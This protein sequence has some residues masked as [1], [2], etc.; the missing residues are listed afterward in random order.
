MVTSSLCYVEGFADDVRV[1][2]VTGG[3]FCFDFTDVVVAT[4]TFVFSGFFVVV[5]GGLLTTGTK[6]ETFTVICVCVGRKNIF[7]MCVFKFDRPSDFR[8]N[9]R[10]TFFI[11]NKFQRFSFTGLPLSRS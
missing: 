10:L 6:S 9:R 2:D 3:V 7:V 1:G 11:C 4:A 8:N 5:E